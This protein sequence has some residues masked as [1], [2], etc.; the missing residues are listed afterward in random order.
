MGWEIVLVNTCSRLR[1]VWGFLL[2]L[3]CSLPS[4]CVSIQ[5]IAAGVL[6]CWSINMLELS[7]DY[8]QWM[9]QLRSIFSYMF[10]F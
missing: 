6:L 1:F 4:G 8:L 7:E 10:P 3:Q 5:Q 9:L 2:D